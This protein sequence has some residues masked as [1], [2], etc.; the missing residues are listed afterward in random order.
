MKRER[1]SEIVNTLAAKFAS[2]NYF[3]IVDAEGLTVEEVNDFRRRCFQAD[4]TYQVVKNT[5]IKRALEQLALEEAVDYVTFKHEVLRGHSGVLCSEDVGS[6]PAKVIQAFRKEKKLKKPL[7][8]GALVDQEL[9]VG[10]QH[11]EALCTLKSKGEL[12][13]ELVGL[14]RGPM[15]Q[16][17]AALQSSNHRIM[18]ALEALADKTE[19]PD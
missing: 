10:E 6:A 4:V 9:W 12:I 5:F 7:L 3:Y 14:L 15:H 13:S 8:K 1:K 17:V 11:L 2:V 19:S 16:V 18:G